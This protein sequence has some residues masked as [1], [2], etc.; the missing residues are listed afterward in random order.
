MRKECYNYVKSIWEDEASSSYSDEE[1]YEA[2]DA[3]M[4]DFLQAVM[5]GE[6]ILCM[7]IH[8]F[9]THYENAVMNELIFS[10]NKYKSEELRRTGSNVKNNNEVRKGILK[11]VM[12]C[13]SLAGY[14]LLADDKR[15][16]QGRYLLDLKHYYK[17]N[18]ITVEKAEKDVWEFKLSKS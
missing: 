4:L 6:F 12:Y 8:K 1:G 5:S 7:K 10:D 2:Y 17:C 15:S 3:F 18:C 16:I 13:D 14:W 9:M 11:R